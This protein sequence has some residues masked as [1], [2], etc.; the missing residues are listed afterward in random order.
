[1]AGLKNAAAGMFGFSLML[2][3]KPSV[4]PPVVDDRVAAPSQPC[5]RLTSPQAVPTMFNSTHV[6]GS[7]SPR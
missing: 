2:T 7:A 6:A 3:V 5:C 1:M 4:V